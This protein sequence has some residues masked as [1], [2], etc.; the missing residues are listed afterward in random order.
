ML[1][2]F[3]E[4]FDIPE[5][6]SAR[7]EHFL[8]SISHDGAERYPDGRKRVKERADRPTFLSKNDM[9]RFYQG[10]SDDDTSFVLSFDDI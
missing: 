2:F 1:F 5:E 4:S 7:L 6:M 3:Q 8:V 9:R 10:D